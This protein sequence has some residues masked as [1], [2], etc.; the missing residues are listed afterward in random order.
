MVEKEVGVSVARCH[1]HVRDRV[2]MRESR[3]RS[4]YYRIRLVAAAVAADFRIAHSLQSRSGRWRRC[5]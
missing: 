1:W 3:A 4:V 2:I 5:R